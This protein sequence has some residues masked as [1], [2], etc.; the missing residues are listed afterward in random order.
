MNE[1]KLSDE[2]R[3]ACVPLADE[4]ASHSPALIITSDEP[5]AIETGRLVAERLNRAA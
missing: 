4:I 1:W 3:R 2:G 5:K